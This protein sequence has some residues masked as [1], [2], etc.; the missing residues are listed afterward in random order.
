MMDVKLLDA[1][2][3]VMQNRSIT[4]AA[5]VLG[6]TQPAVS[7]QVARLETIVGFALFDRSGGR[8][9]AT[10]EGHAFHRE[11][12]QALG[13]ID[14]LERVAEAIRT[15][16]AGKIVV[17]SHPSASISVLPALVARLL[18]LHPGATVKMINRTSEEVR[19]TFEA[20]AVD[21]GI[22]ELPIE[23]TDIEVRKYAVEC[24]AIV[25]RG[26]P[27]ARNRTI[28]AADLSGLPYVSMAQGRL[29]GHRIRNAI[30]EAGAEYKMVAEVEY[31][32]SICGIVAAGLGVSVVDCWS[33]ATFQATGL[34]VRRFEP[35]IDYEIGVFFSS[36]RPLTRIACTLLDMLDER[37]RAGPSIRELD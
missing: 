4:R 34:E 33:A 16:T 25:P 28:T 14:R 1:F 27:L 20:A 10:A 17:A 36:Q 23:L 37:L 3:V 6:V 8:I 7:A 26:H 21:I 24:V 19:G 15:G 35:R 30:V 31:F 29:I 2:R 11:V 13:M 32:S 5:E 22:A 18:A 12:M 9:R